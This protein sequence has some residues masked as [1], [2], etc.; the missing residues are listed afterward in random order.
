[1]DMVKKK[2]VLIEYFIAGDEVLLFG[3]STS[4][5]KPQLIKLSFN[6]CAGYQEFRRTV[7]LFFGSKNQVRMLMKEAP[8]LW[9]RYDFLIAPITEWAAPEDIVYIIPHGLLH[10]LPLHALRI[11]N[12]YL[13]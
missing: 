1:M 7:E 2:I 5:T 3:I 12:Q 11:G 6:S 13:I 8:N 9:H 10:Y 4:F